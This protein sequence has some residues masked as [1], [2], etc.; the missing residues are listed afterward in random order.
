MHG[1]IFD[2]RR[3]QTKHAATAREWQPSR[4]LSER[5]NRA[6]FPSA[7]RAYS[8]MRLSPLRG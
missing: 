3:H 5:L 8:V 6:P 1:G 2:R 7:Q 4:S